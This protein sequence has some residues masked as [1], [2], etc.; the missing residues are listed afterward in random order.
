[1][2]K[3][4]STDDDLY[5][6]FRW[7]QLIRKNLFVFTLVCLR[8]R[9]LCVFF[10][11][12]FSWCYYDS[13]LTLCCSFVVSIKIWRRE[14]G[15]ECW[16]IIYIRM[17]FF[18]CDPSLFSSSFVLHIIL[19]ECCSLSSSW[20]GSTWEWFEHDLA[21]KKKIYRCKFSMTLI[22]YQ[23]HRTHKHHTILFA[24]SMCDNRIII[25]LALSKF[26]DARRKDAKKVHKWAK[27]SCTFNVELK[28]VINC[29]IPLALAFS[30]WSHQN[31]LAQFLRRHPLC[32]RLTWAKKENTELRN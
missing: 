16:R 30:S 32:V 17:F 2:N 14:N 9:N 21:G 25:K 4:P 15:R 8:L 3:I 23:M 5:T 29:C 31:K 26:R 20:N 27:V 22:L 1:M 7:P 24:C 12:F 19:L 10:C 18:I 11:F 13:I 28:S 6:K